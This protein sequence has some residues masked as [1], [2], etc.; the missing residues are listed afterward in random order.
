MISE[1]KWFISFGQIFNQR[2]AVLVTN[3]QSKGSCSRNKF[4]RYSWGSVPQKRWKANLYYLN[5]SKLFRFSDWLSFDFPEE[6]KTSFPLRN[7]VSSSRLVNTIF[8]ACFERPFGLRKR[9]LEVALKAALYWDVNIIKRGLW[10]VFKTCGYEA[11]TK[12]P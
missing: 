1:T 5:A 12:I 3:F 7:D 10:V 6:R 2:V 11:V 4:A 9:R 8:N